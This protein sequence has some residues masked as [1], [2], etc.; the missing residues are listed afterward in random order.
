MDERQGSKRLERVECASG[1]R[2]FSPYTSRLYE[3]SVP[4]GSES[5]GT[6]HVH[7]SR[8]RRYLLESCRKGHF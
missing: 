4:F 8:V 5:I 6:G 3:Q 7:Q 1:F 2:R